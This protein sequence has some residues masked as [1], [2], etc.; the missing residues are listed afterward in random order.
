MQRNLRLRAHKDMENPKLPHY[1]IV[2]DDSEGDGLN[3]VSLVADPAILEMGLAFKKEVPSIDKLLFDF[4]FNGDKQVVVGPAMIPN[5]P[6]YRK[7]GDE[8]FYVVFTKEVIEKLAERFNKQGK[9]HKINVDHDDVVESAFIKSNWI[10]EDKSN[11]KSNMYGFSLPVGTWMLE[12][13]IE[14]KAFWLEHIKEQGKFGFSVEGMFG[15]EFIG[16]FSKEK[17]INNQNKESEMKNNE[18]SAEEVAII[19]KFRADAL[20]LEVVKPEVEEKEEEEVEVKAEDSPE[21]KEEAKADEEAKAEVETAEEVEAPEAEE[22]EEAEPAEL[23]EEAIMALVQP[24]LD[25]LMNAIAEVKALIDGKDAEAEPAESGSPEAFSVMTKL[26]A[27]Q[28][29]YA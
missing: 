9:E 29:F 22:A 10:I 5:I 25:E 13:K 23:D 15:L 27:L 2:L 8:E 26:K 1:N 14:D 12:V 17:D 21:E 7:H 6:L 18:L 16:E 20:K 28:K 4:H 19:E 11:D 3:F 24:K